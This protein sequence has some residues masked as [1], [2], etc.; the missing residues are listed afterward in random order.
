MRTCHHNPDRLVQFSKMSKGV[1]KIRYPQS[2]EK[3]SDCLIAKMRKAAR[4]HDP[5]FIATAVG[6]GFAMDVGFMFQ[7][8]K[9]AARAQ[10]LT[11]VNGN[12]AYCIV[13]DFCSEAIFGVT[14]RGK[15]IPP[16]WLNVL[17]TR[18]SPRGTPGR[19]VRLDLGGETDKNPT[20]QALF[21][22]H[23]Y[24][25]QPTSA[26]ASSQNGM[27]ERPHQTVGMAV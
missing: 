17:L 6:Q 24:I 23:G 18:I 5:G 4:G 20:I 10:R 3:F 1:P 22:K 13:Y 9:N 16:T 14:M 15:T 19:S 25:T 2:I 7:K 27:G 11:G 26:G 12:N 8:S 21:V